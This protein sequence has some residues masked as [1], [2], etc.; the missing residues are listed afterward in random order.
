MATNIFRPPTVARPSR[1]LPSSPRRSSS[2]RRRRGGRS[3]SLW[4]PWHS[5]WRRPHRL[6]CRALHRRGH[7]GRSGR[8]PGTLGLELH[9]GGRRARRLSWAGLLGRRVPL[10]GLHR[11]P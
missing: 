1:S 5:R 10:Q 2:D 11:R 7:V 4:T 3:R 8:S 9:L 6:G